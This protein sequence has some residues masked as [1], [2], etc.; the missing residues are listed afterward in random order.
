MNQVVFNDELVDLPYGIKELIDYSINKTGLLALDELLINLSKQE[1]VNGEELIDYVS[2]RVSESLD[3]YVNGFQERPSDIQEIES[4]LKTAKNYSN[5]VLRKGYGRCEDAGAVIRTILRLILPEEFKV[6]Q[7]N[8]PSQHYDGTHD[9]T[10]IHYPHG[11]VFV[12]S[13]RPE[14]PNKGEELMNSQT[15]GVYTK[16]PIKMLKLSKILK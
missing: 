7:V 12:D 9:L 1:F 11:K 6:S 2:R 10:L 4:C 8:I 15:E 5:N 14:D 16:T 13:I 3:Y